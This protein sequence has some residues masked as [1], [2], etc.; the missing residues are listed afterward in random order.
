M[1]DPGIEC[2]LALSDSPRTNPASPFCVF[3]S[4]IV[5]KSIDS[6]EPSGLVNV[7]IYFPSDGSY[8]IL[9]EYL[10]SVGLLG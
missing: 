9:P 5:L 4:V 3:E 7:N 1:L 6:A 2:M 8:I 10:P